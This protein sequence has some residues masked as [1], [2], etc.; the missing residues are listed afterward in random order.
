MTTFLEKF[1][2]AVSR[3]KEIFFIEVDLSDVGKTRIHH[4][5]FGEEELSSSPDRDKMMDPIIGSCVTE[6]TKAH[7]NLTNCRVTIVFAD[8]NGRADMIIAQRFNG[9]GFIQRRWVD[10][11]LQMRVDEDLYE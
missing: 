9:V 7:R 3:A 1:V 11:N 8:E 2:T 6:L 5:T 10:E 4:N